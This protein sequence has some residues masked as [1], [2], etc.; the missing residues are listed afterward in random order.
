[1]R[2]A[3]GAATFSVWA[4]GEE[5]RPSSSHAGQ[6]RRSAAKTA[7]KSCL[8]PATRLRSNRVAPAGDRRSAA[9]ACRQPPQGAALTRGFQMISQ[10]CPSRSWK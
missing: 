7:D 3:R 4:P 8:P 2:V 9:E 5:A 1:M 6:D 10:R